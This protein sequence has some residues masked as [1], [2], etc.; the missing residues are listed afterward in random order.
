MVIVDAS[1]VVELLVGGTREREVLAA[2]QGAGRL[3]VP[4]HHVAEVLAGLRRAE[5]RQAI[6]ALQAR[7]AVEHLLRAR[8]RS[9]GL[10]GLAAEA[11]ELRDRLTVQDAAYVVL[12]RHLG[13][14]LVTLD[15]G[16]ADVASGL[17]VPVRPVGPPTSAPSGSRRRGGS[18]R[19]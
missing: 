2:L 6:D 8:L 15:G 12:A 5:R 9:F 13:A 16:Q 19:R 10:R 4:G 7:R 1:A 17:G 3:A 14:P 18:S 11:W